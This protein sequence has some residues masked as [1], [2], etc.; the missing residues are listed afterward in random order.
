MSTSE[1]D[2]LTELMLGV[3]KDGTARS[4]NDLDYNIAGKTG[5]AEHGD[6][7]EDTHSWFVGFS[8]A[9]DPDLV[10]AVIAEAAGSGSSV[11]TPIARQVFEAYYGD[12]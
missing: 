2:K 10:V 4:L 11:A 3:V 1:A 7:T 9:E 6:M 5:S 8:N 12:R